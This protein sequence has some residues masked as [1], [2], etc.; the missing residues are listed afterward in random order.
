[1][2]S[3]GDKYYINGHPIAIK[4]YDC[5]SHDVAGKPMLPHVNIY[6]KVSN[7]CNAHCPFCVNAGCRADR[8]E[9][10]ISILTR[11]VDELMQQGVAVNRLCI[12]GG[13]P[14]LVPERVTEILD[15][16][17][18]S[19]YSNIHFQLS[20]NGM[21]MASHELMR[22]P[23]WHY[24]TISLHHYDKK[25]LSELFGIK[26]EPLG[27]DLDGVDLKK[28]NTNCMLI[29]GYI[30]SPIEI[31]KMFDHNISLG[32]PEVGLVSLMKVNDY[33][34]DHFVDFSDIKFSSIPN[35]YRTRSRNRG[36]DCRCANF[37]YMPEPGKNLSVYMRYYANPNYC[38]SS[39]MFDGEHLYQGFGKDSII[40]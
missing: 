13:E 3:L 25:I 24:I 11:T 8:K 23:R 10:D 29:H 14:S 37:R 31:Q 7:A 26:N 12:T 18:A 40:I 27:I 36:E 39:L 4:R 6:V 35:F 22:N 16:F 17:S 33:C 5:D 32:I 28:V 2:I 34:K 21:T 19:R 9:F 38:E 15:I 1:M 20:T 30:D